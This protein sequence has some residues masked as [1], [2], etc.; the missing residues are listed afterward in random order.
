MIRITS[1]ATP[2][3]DSST[4]IKKGEGF[5]NTVTINKTTVDGVN[6]FGHYHDHTQDIE[7][8]LNN[9]TNINATGTINGDTINTNNGNI[10]N[11][12][13]STIETDDLIVNDDAQINNADITT[14]NATTAN[15]ENLL[16]TNATIENLTVTKAAHFY[17]LIIDEVR[18][19]QGQLLITPANA[20]IVNVTGYDYASERRYEL[21]FLA[22]DELTGR[23][24]YNS[25]EIDDQV[26]CQ[27]FNAANGENYN[28]DNRFYWAKVVA[29]STTPINRRVD[30]VMKKCHYIIL[31]WADKDPNTNTIP[32]TGDEVVTLGN[33]TDSTRQSAI[34]IGAYDN[35]FLDS[36][37]KAPFIIQY[38]G[39]NDY[40][41]ATHRKNVISN[42]YNYFNGVFT[43]T[44]GDNIED[45][46]NDITVGALTYIHTAY[47]TSA[48]GQTDFS[49]TYFT[50]ATY[51]GICSNRTESD[52]SLT[53]QDYN[54]M[55]IKGENGGTAVSYILSPISE[56]IGIDANGTV[57]ATLRYNILKVEG[58]SVTKQT[59]SDTLNVWYHLNFENSIT[60][61]VKCQNGTQTPSYVDAEIMTDY[62]TSNN[63]LLSIDVICGNGTPSFSSN[64]TYDRRIIYPSLLPAATF[65][66][67]DSIKSTVQGHTQDINT[68]TNSITTIE[69]DFDGITSTVEQHTTTINNIDDRVSQNTVNISQ[70]SQTAN[71]IILKVNNTGINIDDGT[72]TLN[73]DNTIINGN[74]NLTNANQ[75]LILYDQYGNPKITIQNETLGNLEDFD[76]GAFKQHKTA[77]SVNV[78]SPQYTLTLPTI[79]LG[80]FNAGQQL[81]IKDIT[82]RTFNETYPWETPDNITYSYVIKCN[83]TTIATI[84]GTATTDNYY[85]YF[86]G[87]DNEV[88]TT[89]TYTISIT[90]NGTINDVERYGNWSHN[91]W[92]YVKTTQPDINKIANDGAVFASSQTQYNW[93]GADQTQ[94]RNGNT[95]IR[96]DNN[97][98]ERNSYNPES[99]TFSNNFSDLSSTWP[100]VINNSLT[101]T[102]TAND[103][104]ITF[105][106]VIGESNNAQRT[107]TL[108]LPNTMSGKLFIVKNIVGNN[109]HVVSDRQNIM[110]S[111]SNNTYSDISIGNQTAMFIS[112]GLFWLH[113]NG[114]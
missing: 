15:I 31:T 74:L 82:L 57:G 39:I 67:T 26:V 105:S 30:G 87:Y 16:G 40:N 29:K 34:S 43:T 14:L 104:V 10:T 77:Q 111:N 35:P 106:T 50:S 99:N 97:H 91:L 93:F 83:N 55:R 33:R 86:D 51:M 13:S 3:K 60:A 37:I 64:V 48:D 81:E 107:L 18:S 49:K 32:Q 71:E 69:Q 42:G 88:T 89:G 102:A 58:T 100:Y 38:A 79:T 98:I 63:K 46:I 76:F 56:Q 95:A 114:A 24:I 52:A 36:T 84:T 23:Q 61:W 25:F 94:I 6:I 66:I 113:L 54:W 1:F 5:S 2:K 92:L 7:G 112:C 8:E 45:L 73:G 17:Q 19:N 65:E 44:S 21:D 22:N 59:T 53:Y 4:N 68:L 9:V 41:L 78:Q 108:P 90:I 96:L 27:T 80:Q 103:G 72:I 110:A 85:F 109:T 28:L 47:S 70:I 62:P 75:G 12:N 101:Y 20:K 11:L